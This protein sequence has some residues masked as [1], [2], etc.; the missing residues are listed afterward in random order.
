LA[1]TTLTSA[2]GTLTVNPIPVIV[3]SANPFTSIYPG[4]TTTLSAAV[5][6]NAGANYTWFRDGVVV[7]GATANTLV[8]DV[9]GLGVYKVTVADVNGCSST[10]STIEIKEAAND[11]LFIYPSP[12]T[13]QFQVRYYSELGTT[14]FPRTV[15]VYDGKG[16]RVFTKAY[17]I[18]S[19]YTRIDVDL[20]NQAK[21]LYSVELTDYNGNRIKT[22]RVLVL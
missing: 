19:P 13:G 14:Q 6:P 12:N 17:S 15:N 10:S 22:G 16:T 5:S 18:N 1:S 4:Q 20:K 7:P 21:G 9:D 8:V 2:P 11:I 3:V